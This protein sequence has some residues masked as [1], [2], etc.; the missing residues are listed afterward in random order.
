MSESHAV[1]R[2]V[3]VR[4]KEALLTYF[5]RLNLARGLLRLM[6]LLKKCKILFRVG[7]H[8]GSLFSLHATHI[9]D[10]RTSRRGCWRDVARDPNQGLDAGREQFEGGGR[11]QLEEVG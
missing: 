7:S 10:G 8:N 2:L 9:R 6:L 5:F 3:L 4:V 1:D 11:Q